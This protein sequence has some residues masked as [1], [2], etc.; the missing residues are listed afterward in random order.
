[1]IDK[2]YRKIEK[3]KNVSSLATRSNSQ[4]KGVVE[5]VLQLKLCRKH[6]S[7]EIIQDVRVTEVLKENK[8]NEVKRSR[9]DFKTSEE[10]NDC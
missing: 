4:G 2:N 3:C 1:M 7:S 8:R 9:S 6:M 5:F 10:E